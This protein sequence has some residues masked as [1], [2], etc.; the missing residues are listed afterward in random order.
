MQITSASSLL[1]DAG[2]YYGRVY[3]YSDERYVI[4]YPWE[5]SVIS[6]SNIGPPGQYGI[7]GVTDGN[8]AISL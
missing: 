7:G 4:I 3:Y 5:V 6:S 8:T 1:G 2:S